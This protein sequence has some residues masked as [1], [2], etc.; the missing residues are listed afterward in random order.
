MKVRTLFPALLGLMVLATPARAI[1]PPPDIAERVSQFIAAANAQDVET[2]VT[3]T[4]PNLRWMSLE[5]DKLVVEVTGQEDLRSWLQGYFN[6]TPD[7]RSE[8]GTITVDGAFASA[9]E[10]V[11]Y[12]D[13]DG[14]KASQSSL[15]VYE[16]N[17]DGLIR[18]VWYFPAH[19]LAPAA[20]SEPV[21]AR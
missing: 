3:A 8:L 1:E 18:N 13:G 2:M 11:S 10:T 19:K 12:T 9:V 16:F 21:H 17:G 4:A 15:S 7:A 14:H 6:A 5:Q 20:P